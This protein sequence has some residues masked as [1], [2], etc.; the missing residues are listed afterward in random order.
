[1]TNR[2]VPGN[3]VLKPD[4]SNAGAESCSYGSWHRFHA[5]PLRRGN[6]SPQ[7]HELRNTTLFLKLKVIQKREGRQ[8]TG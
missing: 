7:N 2:Y 3:N 5:I 1:M 6:Q 4:F 8:A